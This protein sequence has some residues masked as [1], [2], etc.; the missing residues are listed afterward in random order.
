M[1]QM[2]EGYASLQRM[3]IFDKILR[4]E[5]NVFPKAEAEIGKSRIVR[6]ENYFKLLPHERNGKYNRKKIPKRF[7]HG[8]SWESSSRSRADIFMLKKI[9]GAALP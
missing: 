4:A 6:S 8:I 9:L 1:A 7:F 5:K 3:D 2:L